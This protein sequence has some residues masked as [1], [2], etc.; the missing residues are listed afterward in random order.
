M[1]AV[2]PDSCLGVGCGCEIS[3]RLVAATKISQERFR[4]D[5]EQVHRAA[6][7]SDEISEKYSTQK[8]GIG[9]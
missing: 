5:V 1:A 3:G 2:L 6:A 4:S 7:P 8:Y 9:L